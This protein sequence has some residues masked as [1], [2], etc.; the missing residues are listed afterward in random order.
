M[1]PVALVGSLKGSGKIALGNGQIAGLDPR[2]FDAVTRAVDQ[3]LPI[4]TARIFDLVSKSL[5]SGQ[6]LIKGAESVMQITAGQLRFSNVSVESKDAA[7][8]V[9]GTLDL[10]DGSIDSRL[11][12]SGSTEATGAPPKNIRSAERAING[13]IAQYSMCRRSPDG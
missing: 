4:E 8:S 9:A 5:E 12:L 7:L 1:S 13:A 11:V 2:T 6:L 10:T 3:G